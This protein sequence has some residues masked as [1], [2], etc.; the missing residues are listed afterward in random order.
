MNIITSL[1]DVYLNQKRLHICLVLDNYVQY[2][3]FYKNFVKLYKSSIKISK[4]NENNHIVLYNEIFIIRV[5]IKE[6]NH[7]TE[8][9]PYD[10]DLF[11]KE[12]NCEFGDSHGF[13]YSMSLYKSKLDD[14]ARILDLNNLK[15]I[16]YNQIYNDYLKN[17]SL[18][19]KGEFL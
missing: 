10:F 16:D 12:Q 5:F 13:I 17:S 6:K 18:M 8:L 14:C 7:Y 4:R 19:K 11:Y 9:V 1:N 15:N 3:Y 2:L